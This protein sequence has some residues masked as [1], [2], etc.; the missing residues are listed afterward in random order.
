MIQ[1]LDLQLRRQL[2]RLLGSGIGTDV[3]QRPTANAQH[4]VDR[5]SRKVSRAEPVASRSRHALLLADRDEPAVIAQS[6]GR[7]ARGARNSK[8]E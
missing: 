2:N 6:D 8:H 1:P 5:F 3:R 7:I 4:G